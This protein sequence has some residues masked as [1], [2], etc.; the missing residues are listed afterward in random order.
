MDHESKNELDDFLKNVSNKINDF[1]DLDVT[2]PDI[3]TKKFKFPRKT[4]IKIETEKD[5]LNDYLLML[6][7]AI[8]NIVTA[9]QMI[10]RNH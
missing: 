2:Q 4:K 5:L 6:I 10:V 1:I 9:S 8:Q 7:V 3:K